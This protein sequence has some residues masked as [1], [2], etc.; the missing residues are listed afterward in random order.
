MYFINVIGHV[1]RGYVMAAEVIVLMG[2]AGAIQQLV[3]YD[4]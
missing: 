2:L 3:G 1:E 4:K